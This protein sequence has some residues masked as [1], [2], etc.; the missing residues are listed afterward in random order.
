MECEHRPMRELLFKEEFIELVRCPWC[1]PIREQ[2]RPKEKEKLWEKIEATVITMDKYKPWS[3]S[4]VIA[5]TAIDEVIK[6]VDE[7][8]QIYDCHK[9]DGSLSSVNELKAKL[10]AMR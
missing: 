5:N 4:K 9:M 10:E 2:E 3:A 1:R 7:C 8:H 6:L